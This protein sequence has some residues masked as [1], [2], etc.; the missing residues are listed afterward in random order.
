MGLRDGAPRLLP[1][2][3]GFGYVIVDEGVPSINISVSG[4][5]TAY[6]E[7]A[8]IAPQTTV[9]FGVSIAFPQLRAS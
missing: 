8:P 6:R 9:R 2:S 3:L 5:W 4:E 7:K 1:L